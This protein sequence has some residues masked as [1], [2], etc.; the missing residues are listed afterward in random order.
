MTTT[1]LVRCRS[2]A[3]ST[4]V[5]LSGFLGEDLDESESES[6]GDDPEEA[7]DLDVDADAISELDRLYENTLLKIGERLGEDIGAGDR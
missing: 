5:L 3:E 4:I 7:A 2:T 6:G 1:D